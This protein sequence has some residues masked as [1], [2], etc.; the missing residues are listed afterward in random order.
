MKMNTMPLGVKTNVAVKMT[1]K[2]GEEVDFSE[3]CVCDGQ[4]EKWL[5]R[6]MQTMRTTIRYVNQ[7][8]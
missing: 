1:A 5:N 6:L 8:E 2:D 7:V 4:V 3:Q